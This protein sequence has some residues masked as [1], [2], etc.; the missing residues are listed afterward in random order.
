MPVEYSQE[1]KSQAKAA[2]LTESSLDRASTLLADIWD[3]RHPPAKSTLARWLKDPQIP[4]DLGWVEGVQGERIEHIRAG[5]VEMYDAARTRFLKDLPKMSWKDFQ[6][7]QFGLGILADKILGK[8]G[9]TLNIDASVNKGARIGT[10]HLRIPVSPTW[11]D[12]KL[13]DARDV[14][15][16]D[17]T[18]PVEIEGETVNL[19][20]HEWMQ[21]FGAKQLPDPGAEDDGA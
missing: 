6:H 2:A 1:Q 10:A 5:T 16:P 13:V 9:T 21:T 8:P 17:G 3:T 18:L 4:A 12:G 15:N 20:P 14:M 7:A 11:V 19:E